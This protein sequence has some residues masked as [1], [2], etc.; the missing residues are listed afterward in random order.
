MGDQLAQPSPQSHSCRHY[1]CHSRPT[2]LESASKL[3][4]LVIEWIEWNHLVCL[5]GQVSLIRALCIGIQFKT[6]LDAHLPFAQVLDPAADQNQEDCNGRQDALA[7]DLL[8]KRSPRPPPPHP[9]SRPF[10]SVMFLLQHILLQIISIFLSALL[11][12]IKKM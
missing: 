7:V 9:T 11:G 1:S 2:K 4:K 3:G 12:S 8:I 6:V 10:S 5:L